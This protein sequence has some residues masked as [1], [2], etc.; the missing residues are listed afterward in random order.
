MLLSPIKKLSCLNQERNK[1]FYMSVYFD[2]REQ[3]GMDI[4]TGESVFLWIMNQKPWLKD[5]NWWT[6]V[7]WIIVMFLS[8]VL[9]HSDG[10]HSLQMIH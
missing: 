1:W 7:V 4:F 3:Q 6:G 9:T 2:V 5:V 10:T 8:A